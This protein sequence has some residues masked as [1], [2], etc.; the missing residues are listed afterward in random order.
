MLNGFVYVV[1]YTGV[2]VLDGLMCVNFVTCTG[3]GV[4]DGLMFAVGGHDGPLIRSTVE[5]YSPQINTWRPAATMNVCRRNAGNVVLS[6]GFILNPD[7]KTAVC[8]K[9]I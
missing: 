4:L 3:V 7:I 1:T 2:V 5:V 9:L 6:V 8:V